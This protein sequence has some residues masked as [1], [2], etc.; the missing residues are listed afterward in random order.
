M[1]KFLY[2]FLGTMAGIWV[3]VLLFGLLILCTIGVLVASGIKSS[4]D[5]PEQAFLR[6]HLSGEIVDRSSNQSFRD[7]MQSGGEQP[8]SLTDIVDAVNAAKD[9]DRIQ[10][11]LLECGDLQA[12]MAQCDEILAALKEFKKEKWVIAYGDNYTQT[13]Y[14]VA[15]VADSLLVNPVGMVDIHGLESTT[16]YFKDL[17]DKV[18]VDMQVVRVGTYKSAVEPFLL[19]DM[20][21]AN[22]EQIDLFLGSLWSDMSATIAENRGVSVD[23][24]N[25]W[26]NS[27]EFAQ[28]A[29]SYITSKVADSLIYRRQLDE[30]IGDL[31]SLDEPNYIELSD[32][33]AAM[34]TPG[35]SSGKGSKTVAVLYALGDITEDGETGIASDR[36]VPLIMELAEDEDIDGLVLRVNSGGGSAFASEQIWEA[37]EEYKAKTGNPFYVSMGDYA[38]SGGYY[39]SCG[40]DKI[41]ASPLTLTGSIG[42]FGIIP[43]FQPLLKDKLG[44]NPVSVGTNKGSF[45]TL[46]SPMSQPQRDAMQEY[47]NRGYELFVGRVAQSR[48]MSVDSVKEIAQG[49]VWDGVSASKNGLVDELGGLRACLEAMAAELD[50]GYS[51][52]NILRYPDVEDQWWMPLLSLS[53]QQMYTVL[54]SPVWEKTE[55]YTRMVNGIVTMYPLQ[56]RANYIIIR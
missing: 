1:K 6:I 34:S 37:L 5:V 3:S 30:F 10:G 11:I 42:I 43:N 26:A 29:E 52:L 41:F 8:T 38:A 20:S 44:V 12:G 47:V 4:V 16:L 54:S 15:S 56:A 9:D 45:P 19:N 2:S 28:P 48:G 23:S 24:V 46:M 32:Y 7:V 39:I 18:G 33:L 36:M 35:S 27:F 13:G 31:L 50:C 55:E 49:R 21:E 53:S 17:L 22:R 25:A 14:F 51:E 40:A